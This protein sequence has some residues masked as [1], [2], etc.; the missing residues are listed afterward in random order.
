MYCSIFSRWKESW[1]FYGFDVGSYIRDAI[2]EELNKDCCNLFRLKVIVSVV[3]SY[4]FQCPP[5]MTLIDR[6]K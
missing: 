2:L 1:W 3:P 4:Q 5:G 6:L